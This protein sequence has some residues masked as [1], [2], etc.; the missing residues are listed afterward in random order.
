MNGK[1]ER[2]TFGEQLKEIRGK[3][4]NISQEKLAE[5]LGV[6]VDTISLSE[7]HQRVPTVAFLD[8]VCEKY[9]PN[10]LQLARGDEIDRS[11]PTEE[12]ICYSR[13]LSAQLD[14]RNAK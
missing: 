13:L 7:R 8:K 2:K 5:V 12:E 6:S 3:N 14:R 10:Y 4:G 1:A 9:P 11:A